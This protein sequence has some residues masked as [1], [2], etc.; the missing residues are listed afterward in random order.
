MKLTIKQCNQ[1][2]PKARRYK[3][4]DGKGLYLEVTPKGKKHW[5]LKYHFA[6]KEKRISF[7]E[8]PI[9]TLKQAR[10][11]RHEALKLLDQSIDPSQNRISIKALENRA[12]YNS[13]E[14]IAREWHE[15][16][17]DQW[18]ES[19]FKNVHRRLEKDVFPYI[20]KKPV[21]QISVPEMLSVLRK[22]EN[23]NAL[24]LLK[25]TRNICSQ[26][27]QYGIQTGRCKEN[28]VIHL[29]GAFKAKQESHYPAIDVRELPEL[30]KAINL[31]EPRLY[32]RTRRAIWLSMLTFC[33]PKEIRTARWEHINFAE[34]E[35]IIPASMMKSKRDHVVPLATQTIQI[36]SAQLEE[37]GRT[38]TP[39]VFPSQFS[40]VK[41]MSE[42][43][44]SKAL[45]RLGYKGKMTAH[46]F[47]ALARTAI[48]EKLKYYPDIIEAQLAH[49][50]SGPLGR[51]Y[52]RA[53]FLDERKQMMQDWADFIDNQTPSPN[54]PR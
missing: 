5:R 47:R 10:D 2:K 38:R 42:A 7:G 21:S 17:K 53:Q 31:N 36:L 12:H 48:R 41:P 27:F 45:H 35:W 26:V 29:R 6:G 16:R 20:G 18:S 19:H 1:L 23:R 49:K 14:R 28:P 4:F 54:T 43:T 37:V 11:K 32:S 44:V 33:R 24:D 46:G 22:I 13:F 15:L 50:P 51:A 30:I 9:V 3:K 39:W 34:A 40:L 8:Y 52:D 25:K